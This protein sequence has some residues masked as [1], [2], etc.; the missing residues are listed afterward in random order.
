MNYSSL[1]TIIAQTIKTNGQNY[2]TAARLLIELERMIDCLG[3]GYQFK[4]IAT[5]S[6]T[7][8]EN[9]DE[10][11]FYIAGPGTYSNFSE[12][13]IIREGCIGF[14]KYNNRWSFD[15]IDLCSFL[16]SCTEDG[17]Y[18]TD[19]EGNIAAEVTE[20]GFDAAKIT[21]RF[22]TY[23]NST[24][25]VENI[26]EGV[27]DIQNINNGAFDTE[28]TAESSKLINSG[29]IKAALDI[30]AE[31]FIEAIEEHAVSIEK[32]QNEGSIIAQIKIGE[33]TYDIRADGTVR[34]EENGFF[35]TDSDKNIGIKY[36][37]NGLDVAKL[38]QHFLSLIN[39]KPQTQLTILETVQTGLFVVD[40]NL[41]I[42]LRVDNSGVR[43]KKIINYEI[44][45]E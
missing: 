44:I 5:S 8:P 45:D 19:T 30:L 25:T 36:D 9:P 32:L 12:I 23:L 6:T 28:P 37:N 26:G 24:L 27:V 11:I 13:I 29:A 10:R 16:R 15:I 17:F 22:K 14:F 33:T 43:A 4:G 35:I 7:P 39:V 31:A 2:I 21:E 3:N 20:N 18:I 41:N 38:S 34:V 40:K 1:K 42:G